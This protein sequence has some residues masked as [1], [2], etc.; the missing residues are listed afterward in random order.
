METVHFE[1]EWERSDGIQGAEL[2]TTWAAFRLMV[3]KE[4]LTRVFDTHARTVRSSIFIPLYPLAEWIAWNW[5]SLLYEPYAHWLSKPRHYDRRH[6]MLFVCD[7]ITM[8]S[9]EFRPIGKHVQV[10]WSPF[11]H[12]YQRIDYLGQGT[13]VVD[14]TQLMESLYALVESVCARLD[15]E[16]I[17]ETSLLQGWKA[18]KESIDDPEESA[19]CQAVGVQGK[20]PYFLKQSEENNILQAA[21]MVP[22]K[23]HADFFH[24]ASWNALSDQASLLF[25]DIRWIEQNPGNWKKLSLLRATMDA[26][27]KNLMPWDQGYALARTMRTSLGCNG[28]KFS[29]LDEIGH[30]LGGSAN[31][32]E[33]STQHKEIFTGVEAVVGE[34]RNASPGFVFKPR[35]RPE[36]VIFT[37]CRA[38]CDYFFQPGSPSLILETN[39]ETQKRNR[40]F[41]AEFLAPA[42]LIQ[43]RLAGRETTR[44]EMD[45]IAY[46]MG[47]SSYVVAHH[48]QNHGL[49]VVRDDF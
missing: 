46:M 29:S 22:E 19:F 15:Q 32:L 43:S 4:C 49:A 10:I 47:V 9:V 34:N 39:T 16:N 3:G 37:F 27:N 28:L 33:Q 13:A 31:Q 11:Q 23:L 45:E 41:A 40:A 7:G 25:R 48:V 8:P 20:D 18:I 30:I 36:N 21:G 38:M 14:H 12:P 35:N 44:E 2:G 5:W 17:T 6:N 42:E 1:F 26:P 24:V